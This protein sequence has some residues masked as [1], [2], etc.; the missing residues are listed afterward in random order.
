MKKSLIGVAAIS[1]AA[2]CLLAG[3]GVSEAGGMK[4]QIK[5]LTKMPTQQYY[6]SQGQF[7]SFI[8]RNSTSVVHEDADDKIWRFNIMAFFK[9]RL[10]DSEVTLMFYDA[11][12]GQQSKYVDSQIKMTKDYNSDSLLCSVTL[13]RPPF[14]A[15]KRYKI[16]AQ[17]KDG[18]TLASGTFETRGTTTQAIDAQKRFENTQK[19]MEKSM[20]ELERKA[21]EQ[22]EAEKRRKQKENSQA[23]KDLF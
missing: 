14:D 16:V 6:K 5:I 2:L 9:K 20:K 4:G 23:A 11:D 8:R 3:L 22:E 19:E 15:N 17:D 18:N 1:V 12:P 10:A 7:H 13:H 21:K